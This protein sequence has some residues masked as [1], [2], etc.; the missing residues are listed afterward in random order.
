M[1]TVLE[2]VPLDPHTKNALLSR[3]SPLRDVYRLM[4]AQES[5][6]WDA[7][8]DLAD[9][10]RLSAEQVADAHWQ[11]IQWAQEVNQA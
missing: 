2:K 4:L 8:A 5:G 1:E 6:E 10:M 3:P 9:Q 11:A 7:V